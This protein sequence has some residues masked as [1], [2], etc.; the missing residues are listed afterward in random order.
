MYQHPHL[1]NTKHILTEQ[2]EVS[3]YARIMFPKNVVQIEHKVPIQNSVFP[4]GY[5]IENLILY[6]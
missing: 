3:F 2:R 5:G 1:I 4:G 6:H